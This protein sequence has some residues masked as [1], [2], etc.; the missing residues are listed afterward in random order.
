MLTG[1]V[2]GAVI[3]ALDGTVL[4]I[5]QPTLQRDLGASFTQVQWTSTGYLIAVA[6]LLV[7]AGR[8]GDR[9]GHHRLF[10]VGMLGFGA[11]SAGIG[12]ASGVGW[13]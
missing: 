9:Y 7:F 11:A 1:S 3:V 4:T 10:A 13:V 6:S 5:A 8:L 2:L 12:C